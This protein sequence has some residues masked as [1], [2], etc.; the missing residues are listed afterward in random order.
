MKTVL[1]GPAELFT[2]SVF[3]E[4]AIWER[5]LE[6]QRLMQS[7]AAGG[8]VDPAIV[9]VALPGLSESACRNLLRTLEHMKLIEA[10]GAVSAFG[11]RCGETGEAPAWELGVFTFLVA[12][13]PCFG[14]W[15]VGFRRER[16]EWKDLDYQSLGELPSWFS[17]K[18]NQIW[19]SGFDDKLRFTISSFPSQPGQSTWCRI[20]TL[21]PAQMVWAIDLSTGKNG[22]HVEGSIAGQEGPAAFRTPEMTVPVA[23]ITPLFSSWERRWSASAGRVLLSYDGAANKDGR[24]SFIRTITYPNVKAGARGTFE[25]ARVENVPVGPPGAPEAREWATELMLARV[26]AADTYVSTEGWS[27][28][29]GATITGTPLQ[30][31]AGAAP[32]VSAL[33]SRRTDLPPRLRWLLATGADLAME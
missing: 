5:R 20:D 15:P 23:E 28:D 14:S 33:V 8:K 7:G 21:P 13:H 24:D 26:A 29:W 25:A 32:D 11:K 1:R 12:K 4:V 9:A 19:T 18:S 30:A 10:N 3:A 16:A 2:V 31:G 6:L 17:A 27:R 22:V